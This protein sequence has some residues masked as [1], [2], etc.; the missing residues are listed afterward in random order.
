MDVEREGGRSVERGEMVARPIDSNNRT[1]LE[2][3]WQ[4]LVRKRCKSHWESLV[5]DSSFYMGGLD[6]GVEV[7]LQETSS[8]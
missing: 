6:G 3:G 8:L 2:E 7:V 1:K 4:Q 5:C